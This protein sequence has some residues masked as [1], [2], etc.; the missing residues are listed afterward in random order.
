[1]LSPNAKLRP[2]VI[3]GRPVS[4]SDD[5]GEATH[6]PVSARM[7]WARLLKRVFDIEPCGFQTITFDDFVT[8]KMVQAVEQL[9]ADDEARKAM[10]EHNYCIAR[11]YF[12]YEVL[13]EE[14]RPI[15]RTALKPA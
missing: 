3:T 5:L 9:L 14:L 4:V 8:V 10:V 7:C 1:V 6:Q 11:Q 2:Q 13:E 15:L 12:S